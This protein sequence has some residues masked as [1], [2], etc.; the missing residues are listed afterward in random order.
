MCD[1]PMIC[2]RVH[3]PVHDIYV[4]LRVYVCGCVHVSTCVCAGG[5][6]LMCTWHKHSGREGCHW[7]MGHGFFQLAS[8]PV[9][10]FAELRVPS[11]PPLQERRTLR[12][13]FRAEIQL[14]SALKGSR[15]LLHACVSGC[16]QVSLLLLQ[17]RVW[18]CM[19][20][21]VSGLVRSSLS[22]ESTG[23]GSGPPGVTEDA[24]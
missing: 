6:G 13:T 1:S 19:D 7:S 20:N 9:R 21:R 2:V 12:R 5:G 11:S 8:A 14:Y 17:E 15:R 16:P 23:G 18:L 4:H 22:S 24:D 3:V 10:P